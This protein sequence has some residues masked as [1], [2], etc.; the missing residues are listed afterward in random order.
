MIS[1]ND[2]SIFAFRIK[3]VVDNGNHTKKFN[4]TTDKKWVKLKELKKIPSTSTTT[5]TEA[6]LH[7][8]GVYER[9]KVDFVWTKDLEQ[10]PIFTQR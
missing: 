1:N 4:Q 5:T 6:S 7:L 8:Q 2:L 10:F 3:K 9:L